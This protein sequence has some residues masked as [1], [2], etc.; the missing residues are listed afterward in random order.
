MSA[1]GR[2]FQAPTE[3]S[4]E[5]LVTAA[6]FAGLLLTLAYAF[7]LVLK[8]FL[9]ALAWASVLAIGLQFLFQ[10]LRKRLSAGRAAFLTTAGVVVAFIVPMCLLLVTLG[11]ECVSLSAQLAATD[12]GARL[13]VIRSAQEFWLNMQ[14]WFP[15]LHGIEPVESVHSGILGASK[16]LAGSAGALAQNV[17]GFMALVAIV[18]IALFFFLRDGPALAGW[19][20][21][22]LPLETDVTNRLFDEIRLLIEGSVM[23]TLLVAIVQGVLGAAATAILGFPAPLI[24]G[25]AFGFCSFVPLFGTALVWAPAVLWLAF[26]GQPG[27]A[28]VLLIVSLLLAQTDNVLRPRL[29]MGRSRLNLGVS[30]LSVLGGVAAFG[31][32]GL[33]L[34]PVVVALVT[35]ILDVYL[36]RKESSLTA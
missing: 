3:T 26:T 29:V 6:L 10:K 16:A 12:P 18:P 23:A 27:K 2:G 1:P 4:P 33:V 36:E 22:L 7:F 13:Q 15:A 35:A 17:A 8:P 11:R 30:L 5:R 25:V 21:R 9:A 34:G 31:A 14:R 32:L 20:R 24:W 28:L 19:L